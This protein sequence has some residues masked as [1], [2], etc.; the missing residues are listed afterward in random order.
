MKYLL[1][2]HT[3]YWFFENPDKLGR[4]ARKILETRG[5]QFLIPSI[6]M[7]ELKYIFRKFKIL[8]KFKKV[9]SEITSDYNC[10]ILPLNEDIVEKMDANLEMHDSIIITSAINYKKIQKEDVK[11]ITKDKMIQ[12]ISLVDTIW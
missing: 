8:N 10:I 5:N 3:I 2:T 12:K 1:D 9:F 4:K 7:A 11:I 6:V